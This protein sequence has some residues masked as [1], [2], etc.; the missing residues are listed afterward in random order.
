MLYF[1]ITSKYVLLSLET[2]SVIHRLS[3]CLTSRCFKISPLH[4]WY[5]LLVYFHCDRKRTLH[6]FDSLS[7]W[8]FVLWLTMGSVPVT[9][10]LFGYW[11]FFERDPGSKLGL[12]VY[13]PKI[14]WRVVAHGLPFFCL[15]H[16]GCEE[17]WWGWGGRG[18][19][20]GR[21]GGEGGG[22]QSRRQRLFEERPR[23]R[24]APHPQR[25]LAWRPHSSGGTVAGVA[26][27]S[28]T[29][30]WPSGLTGTPASALPF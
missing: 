20:R 26:A 8:R 25:P 29:S 10:W 6:N 7:L 30:P 19:V 5:W 16:P 12:F 24:Q 28:Q 14:C 27:G 2:S 13:S 9:V 21:G 17:R 11:V 15:E 1:P 22:H 23:G 18:R 3:V 4:F